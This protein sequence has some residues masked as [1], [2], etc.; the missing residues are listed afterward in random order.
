MQKRRVFII[1]T[2]IALILLLNSCVG[3]KTKVEP[4]RVIE[5][6]TQSFEEVVQQADRFN[7]SYGA[8]NVLI[9]L[10]IDNTILTSSVDL[11]G[12]IWYQW[13][14]KKLDIKPIENQIVPCLFEDSIGLLYEIC[15]MH[16]TDKNLP[17]MIL[18]WTNSGNT[19]MA[20]TSRAPKYR[21]ATERELE[22]QDV[23]F[24][25]AGLRLKGEDH[26][27]VFRATL[28]GREWS[29]MKGIMMVTGMNKGDM[30]TMLL[31]KTGRTFDAI[32]F[33]D[34]SQKNINAMHQKF[35]EED[36]IEVAIYH[37]TAIEEKR[38][39]NQGTILTEKQAMKMATDWNK[40][41]EVLNEIF[42]AR[43][44]KKGDCLSR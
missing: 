6:E 44:L 24:E 8:E 7:Q 1:A 22:R 14:R 9:V 27:P 35:R 3:L 37:Y 21:A 40:L 36:G 31:E 10:D 30:L 33:V 25:R 32:I 16:L 28:N 42:P 26:L 41:N 17:G 23:N 43:K 39:E 34:D 20:L 12:D 4:S 38:K 15:P 18:N 2:Q 29:Y 19:I 13:Q 5:K 11:G